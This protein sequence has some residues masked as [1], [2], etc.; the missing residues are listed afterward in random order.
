MKLLDET[1]RCDGDC[2]VVGPYGSSFDGPL[3]E[4]TSNTDEDVARARLAA[5]APDM[6]RLLLEH[7]WDTN[8]VCPSCRG[9][10]IG[11]DE[12][13]GLPG[14]GHAP[15]CKLIGVLRMAGVAS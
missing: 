12:D 4:T 11:D 9:A 5:T 3:F 13:V 2:Y 6:A 15:G 7:Q 10:R 1:W 8:H 14:Y